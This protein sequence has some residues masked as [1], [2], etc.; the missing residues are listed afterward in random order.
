M[1][2]NRNL[3]F[4]MVNLTCQLST[5]KMHS[6]IQIRISLAALNTT[7]LSSKR[8]RD[9]L[10]ISKYMAKRALLQCS[11]TVWIRC[12]QI[13]TQ[14]IQTQT[15]QTLQAPTTINDNIKINST[16]KTPLKKPQTRLKRSNWWLTSQKSPN[17]TSTQTSTT[18]SS[19]ISRRSNRKSRSK[20][21]KPRLTERE[22]RSWKR[23]YSSNRR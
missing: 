21:S 16:I 6:Q 14:L 3:Q 2:S 5:T 20:I 12:T 19:P 18:K 22:P 17:P 7:T 4:T 1:H 10:T 9:S 23:N 13:T 11:L 8:H 15:T